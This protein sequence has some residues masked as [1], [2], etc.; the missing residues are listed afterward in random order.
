MVISPVPGRSALDEKEK[1]TGEVVQ[2][3]S[4]PSEADRDAGHFDRVAAEVL[5][6]LREPGYVFAPGLLPR[7]F[8]PGNYR[9]AFDAAGNRSE[10]TTDA[11]RSRRVADEREKAA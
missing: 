11:G 6:V 3:V 5:R 9:D 8:S 1:K 7:P 4:E 10:R 2:A